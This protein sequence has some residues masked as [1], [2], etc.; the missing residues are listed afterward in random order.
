MVPTVEIF[1]LPYVEDIKGKIR[2]FKRIVMYSI[3]KSKLMSP[4]FSV[5]MRPTLSEPN[6]TFDVMFMT[7]K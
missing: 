2:C 7:L 3:S 5:E 6:L 4:Y 1:N